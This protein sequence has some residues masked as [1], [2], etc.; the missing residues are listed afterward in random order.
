LRCRDGK[1]VALHMSSPEKFW[2]GLA[3]AIER[4]QLF[5]DPRFADRTARIAHQEDLIMLLGDLFATRDR[6][7][8]CERLQAE[9]VPHAPM[10]D[11]SEALQDP[12]ARHMEIEIEG[13]HPEMG[14]W[15]TVRSPV[16]FDGVRDREV[17]PPPTL[18]EH[19]AEI[20][21]ALAA[22]RQPA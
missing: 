2:Q 20:R 4:P 13:H 6:A 3:R 22:N 9:D 1:W 17:T 7:D 16:S 18:G 14:R 8:W 12:Q 5:A 11:T 10:Y 19:D 21:A 15:R